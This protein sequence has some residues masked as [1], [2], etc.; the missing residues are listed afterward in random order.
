MRSTTRRLAAVLACLPAFAG[1]SATASALT[2]SPSGAY[3]TAGGAVLF[4]LSSNGQAVSCPSSRL[5]FTVAADGTGTLTAG[6]AVFNSCNS[7]VYGAF[8][9]T[10]VSDWAV[11]V[12]LATTRSGTQITLGYTIPTAGLNVRVIGCDIW[13]SGTLQYAAT[14]TGA[15]P[16]TL[17]TTTIFSATTT[18][19][20]V[21]RTTCTPIFTVPGLAAT[22]TGSYTLD[23]AITIS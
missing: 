4:R 9:F 23:R 13:L 2:V 17:P 6:T 19:L 14:S 22:L 3:R 21:D 15:L 18:A 1:L 5:P 16:L 7:G 12:Q 8:V 11:A 20:T 10:A